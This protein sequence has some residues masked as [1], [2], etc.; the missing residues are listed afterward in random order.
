[1]I[2]VFKVCILNERSAST[3]S[4][5]DSDRSSERIRETQTKCKVCTA[6][7]RQQALKDQHRRMPSGREAFSWQENPSN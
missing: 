1:M 4:Q 6:S 3:E 7:R 5:I 2:L